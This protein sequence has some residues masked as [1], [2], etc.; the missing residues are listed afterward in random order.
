LPIVPVSGFILNLSFAEVVFMALLFIISVFVINISVSKAS[1]TFEFNSQEVSIKIKPF[2]SASLIPSSL[3]I[4]LL[5]KSVLFPNKMI[6]MPSLQLS[7][8]CC[9]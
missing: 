2:S 3:G 4:T 1:E 5:S 7:F 8:I 6:F 9:K